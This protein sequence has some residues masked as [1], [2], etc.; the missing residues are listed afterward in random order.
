MEKTVNL[1]YP[2]LHQL[3]NTTKHFVQGII[4]NNM[5]LLFAPLLSKNRFCNRNKWSMSALRWNPQTEPG[6]Y[7]SRTKSEGRKNWMEWCKIDR[8]LTR[9]CASSYLLCS[10]GLTVSPSNNKQ[11]LCP[12]L[13]TASSRS[14]PDFPLSRFTP[15]VEDESCISFSLHM[16]F[17]F[18][19]S[20]VSIS[21]S[22]PVPVALLLPTSSHTGGTEG[23][24][25]RTLSARETM[26]WRGG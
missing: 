26:K 19:M 6:L 21:F 3:L 13:S 1:W 11:Q 23:G 15:V 14:S 24:K 5:Y 8:G 7:K 9:W 25:R 16:I 18:D 10:L 2:T 22:L 17:F 20:P 4:L 12:S